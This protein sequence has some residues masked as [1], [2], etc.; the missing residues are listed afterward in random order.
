[1]KYKSKTKVDKNVQGI[2]SLECVRAIRKSSLFG[3]VVKVMLD[4]VEADAFEGDWICQKEDGRW[5]VES[6][7]EEG[8]ER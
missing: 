3:I 1:M 7:A 4:G 2:F 6:D 8:G 5:T